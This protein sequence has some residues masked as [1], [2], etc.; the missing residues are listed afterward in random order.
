MAHLTTKERP[1]YLK[2]LWAELGRMGGEHDAFIKVIIVERIVKSLVLIT[3]AIGLIFAS[4]SGLLTQSA[5]YPQDQL[6]LNADNNV[7]EQVL[8]RRS[9]TARPCSRSARCY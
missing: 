5:D 9:S 6:N 7:I 4:R 8:F 2:R 1:H 3:L